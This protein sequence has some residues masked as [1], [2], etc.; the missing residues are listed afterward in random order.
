MLIGCHYAARAG[1]GVA[2][3]RTKS[4]AATHAPAKAQSALRSA[5]L[6]RY[7][8]ISVLSSA[9]VSSEVLPTGFTPS[10]N[11]VREYATLWSRLRTWDSP[12]GGGYDQ[13][14]QVIRCDCGAC[15]TGR[16]CLGPGD[17]ALLDAARHR[18]QA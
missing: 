8:A 17:P 5:A 18:F 4:A 3:Q 1:D 11:P 13:T 6:A 12:K 15:C 16:V 14:R 10:S 7:L 9:A 2:A